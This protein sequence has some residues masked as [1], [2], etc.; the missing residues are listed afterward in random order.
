[1]T[2][3][4]HPSVPVFQRMRPWL[5]GLLAAV[6]L[7]GLYFFLATRGPGRAGSDSARAEAV[8][9]A[10]LATL[11]REVDALHA[12]WQAAETKGQGD[13]AGARESLAAAVL[14]QRQRVRLDARAAPAESER[15]RA[16][17]RQLADLEVRE[18]LGRISALEAEAQAARAGH[19]SD[20]ARAKLRAAL[21]LMAQVNRSNAAASRKDISRETRMRVEW[22]TWEAEP[23][24][25]L[26]QDA[27]ARAERAAADERPEE[28][29]AAF[30]E[31]RRLQVRINREYPRTPFV[32]L[33]VED[34]L[35]AQIQSLQAAPQARSVRESVAAAEE[36][37]K[38]GRY[39]EAARGFAQALVAQETINTTLSRSRQRSAAALEDI[40]ARRQTALSSEALG[41]L[42]AL[43][44]AIV[45]HLR[46][47]AVEQARE[48]IAESA[49][50][51]ARVWR[52]YP[53][54]Q[55]LDETLRE[56]A[57]YRARQAGALSE[58]RAELAAHLRPPA[59]ASLAVS[60]ILAAEVSQA[61]YTRIMD[62]NPSRNAGEARP[63]DSVNWHE[64]AEF[65][66]RAG[67]LLGRSVRLPA[68]A[69]YRG[70]LDAPPA[71]VSGLRGGLAEWLDAPAGAPEA[72]V[73][74]GSYLDTRET[75]AGF[76][77]QRLAKNERARHVGFRIVVAE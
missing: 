65:C 18:T 61:L 22:E 16:L 45:Q 66:R 2:D 29:R 38:A 7:G 71:E 6:A 52:E 67:W 13:A 30:E 40:E 33:G 17:E 9:A 32:D 37:L 42:S 8:G 19:R 24:H 58:I 20:E 15:L 25:Q 69:E 54:S 44:E 76:P 50:I 28:A 14:K 55:R 56:R 62:K 59:G 68:E 75:L 72:A 74:G 43:E 35:E 23:L 10:D 77:L 41:R 63:V 11:S 46:S 48:K 47:G 12:A 64:A 49:E 36:N 57:L 73:A 39:E 21:D 34:Q 53:R 3:D 5:L 70:L 26:V 27:R 4:E 1:M 51:V 60:Q 31:I